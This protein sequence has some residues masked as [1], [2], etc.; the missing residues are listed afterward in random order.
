MNTLHRRD[1]LAGMGSIGLAGVS[2]PAMAQGTPTSGGT[3]TIGIND[4]TKTLDP[5]FSIQQAERQILH[6]LYNTLLTIDVDFSLKPELAKSWTV[7]NDGKRYVFQL[8]D[9]VKF[10]DGTPFDAAAVKFNFERR[11]DEKI[12]SPQRTQLAPIIDSVE[13]LSPLSFAINLKNPSPGLLAELADRVGFMISPT[14]AE[15]YGKDLGTNPVGTGAFK[16]KQWTQG[17]ELTLE[18]NPNYWESGKP[19]LDTIVFKANPNTAIGVQR[20]MVGE[21]DY[22]Y[23]LQPDALRQL[24]D[25]PG[26]KTE[27][28]K[29]GR[30]YTYEWQVDKPP[31]DNPKLR[32]AIAHAIDRDRLNQITMEGQATI[33]NGPIPSGLWWSS[34]DNVVY[35]YDV[36]KAK[37]LLA[38]AGIAPGTEI[39]MWTTPTP[40][41]RRLNQLVA[42]QLAAIGLKINIIPAAIS[43]FYSR[44][45]S[46]A[47]N[48]S[49]TNWTQRAD[50]DGLL[51]ILFHSK[52]FAN[53]TGYNNPKVDELLASGRVTQ[54]RERRKQIY[55]EIKDQIMRDLP[56]IPIFFA[57]EFAG[58]NSKLNGVV[59]M[60]D[61]HP[62]FRYAWK[63]K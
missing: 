31:F 42:E 48:F 63:V 8:Q 45:V 12:A 40:V 62:R 17:T 19:Y 6:L 59:W 37:K 29:I 20:L 9:N 5:T 10:Q 58:Y 21:I 24:G 39:P 43:D 1:V 13:V 57:A 56:Y 25:K 32:Q 22:I 33:A 7:E 54:D 23:G 51:F 53:V 28:S 16:L 18:R 3:L 36:E 26:I 38:E 11:L 44:Q 4:D 60:P 35:P 34:P 14:A 41:D 15:K 46:R 27:K 61:N 47:I 30:W 50:P 2:W 52:G 55:A 49:I